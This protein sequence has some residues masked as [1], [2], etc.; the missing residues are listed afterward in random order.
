MSQKLKVWFL[1]EKKRNLSATGEAACLTPWS[2]KS[3]EKLPLPLCADKSLEK[4]FT[5]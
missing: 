4:Y 3:L 2:G 5:F 1:E